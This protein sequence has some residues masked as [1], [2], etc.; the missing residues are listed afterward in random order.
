[1]E[2]I[3]LEHVDNLGD[4]GD[5]VQ[6]KNGYARNYLL[7]QKK[8]LRATNEN[9]AFFEAKRAQM[10]KELEAYKKSATKT[11]KAIE[12]I[13]VVLLRQAGE[14][15]RLFGSVSGKDIAAA[16]T[17]T[18]TE[19]DRKY[20]RLDKPIKYIGVHPVKVKL[21]ADIIAEVRVN[22]ART[23][24]EAKDAEYLFLNPPAKEEVKQE[25][26]EAA[27][28]EETL[29]PEA[30]AEVFEQ[31]TAEAKKPKGKKAKKKTEDEA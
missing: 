5:L 9:K 3:L 27:S 17:A 15:G 12:G 11:A 13:F 28:T 1:M 31:V 20:L 23:E 30:A 8:C 26:V 19:L 7:P 2:V 10:E 4:L 24:D 16:V 22:V 6:V 21:H 14:D 29:S 25:Y 18:G